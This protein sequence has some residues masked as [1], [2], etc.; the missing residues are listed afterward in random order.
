MKNYKEIE[1]PE[2]KK[3]IEGEKKRRKAPGPLGRVGGGSLPYIF[4]RDRGK[5]KYN[6][7]IIMQEN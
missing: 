4:S 7:M 6:V 5:C 1:R 2:Y 3:D